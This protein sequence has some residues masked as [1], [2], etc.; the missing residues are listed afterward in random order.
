MEKVLTTP[1]KIEL[2]GQVFEGDEDLASDC[3]T[4]FIAEVRRVADK[5]PAILLNYP[6]IIRLN[7]D[8]H[9]DS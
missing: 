4:T 7:P 1:F 8:E 5:Y 3:L 2:Q 6:A 9:P